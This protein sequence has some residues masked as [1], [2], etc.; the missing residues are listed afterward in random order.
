M[1]MS[2]QPGG[3]GRAFPSGSARD[4]HVRPAG[5]AGGLGRGQVRPGVLGMG[6]SGREG[7]GMGMSVLTG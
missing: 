5:R 2:V 7:L 4:G 6:M 3:P 1:G